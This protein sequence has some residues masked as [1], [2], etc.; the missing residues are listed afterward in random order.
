MTKPAISLRERL[1][2]AAGDTGFNFVWQTLELYLLFYYVRVLGLA[3][4]L[5]AAIFLVGAAVD[6]VSD[7]LVGILLDRHRDRI[8]ARGW[9]IIA[10][11]QL[12]LALG[13][14]FLPPP[15]AGPGAIAFLIATHCLLRVTYALGNIPYASLTA[16]I[17]P[18]PAEHIRLTGIRL[19]GAAIGGIVAALVYFV[20]PLG[21]QVGAGIPL[22]AIVLG[23]LAQPLFFLTWR[24]VHE[25]VVP[26]GPPSASVWTQM[27]GIADL[28]RR[29][30]DLRRMLAQVFASGLACTILAK[31]LLFV[32]DRLG[33]PQWGYG[34]AFVPPNMLLFAAPV[35]SRLG[36]RL[37][38]ARA[39]QFACLV[40]CVAIAGALAVA[41][42]PAATLLMVAFASLAAVG[43]SLMF[44]ALVPRV[45]EACELTIAPGGCA[46]R[47][48][49][50]A[51]MA[52]KSASGIAPQAIALA[53]LLPDS[54]V[55]HAALGAAILALLTAV[56]YA[57]RP[58][59]TRA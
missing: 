5:A 57:P 42:R 31:G 48:F 25:R 22:G 13:L 11:P 2:F 45:V 7:P 47:I 20:L 35:W 32:F 37:G 38:I 55:L 46:A 28:L 23:L 19:Q 8:S 40:N 1:A 39:L 29:S 21:A 44:F 56:F 26:T 49:G 4:G 41:G 54:Q 51:S 59:V 50:L 52:R 17:S 34:A 14:A 24:G 36:Q 15:L 18:D 33:A 43:M 58:Q 27:G 30:A 12:G 3:P 9:M 10:G 16:R 6:L 53:L